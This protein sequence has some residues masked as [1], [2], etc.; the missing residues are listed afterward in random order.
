[1]YF[2]RCYKACFREK[3]RWLP[4]FLMA[5]QIKMRWGTH[6]TFCTFLY[7]VGSFSCVDCCS[8]A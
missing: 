1:V 3:V 8:I 4:R 2:F 6:D 7:L 5:R